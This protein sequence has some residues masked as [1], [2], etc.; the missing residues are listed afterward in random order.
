MTQIILPDT[1]SSVMALFDANK[2]ALNQ[3]AETV[4]QSVKDG[5]ENPLK[6]HALIKKQ[7]FA[8]EQIKKG[9]KEE[10]KTEASKYGE[11]P[12][13]FA[14]A[15][16][17]LTSVK[18]E[19]D[20]SVCND[21]ELNNL[22]K[23]IETL[24]KQLKQREEMLKSLGNPIQLLDGETGEVYTVYPPMKKTETGAKVSLK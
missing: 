1:P 18:T 15:E 6:I 14:G 22:N 9:I 21:K 20:Y 3:F 23:Q 13:M 10:V 5:N 16:C 11:K 12:F 7:E 2:Q 8:L 17:H 4:I 19:Y 24:K